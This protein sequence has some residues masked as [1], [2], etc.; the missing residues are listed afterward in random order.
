MKV[1]LAGVLAIAGAANAAE[2]CWSDHHVQ[3]M[4]MSDCD[5]QGDNGEP[6][7]ILGSD[8]RVIVLENIDLHGNPMPESVQWVNKTHMSP[9]KP[10][11]L[12]VRKAEG[13]Q[14]VRRGLNS[15]NMQGWWRDAV[16]TNTGTSTD[17]EYWV[18][19]MGLDYTYKWIEP[20]TGTRYTEQ[21][22]P[23]GY[24]AIED[25]RGPNS[26]RMAMNGGFL[27]QFESRKPWQI[28]VE[29]YAH[30]PT[31]YPDYMVGVE[32]QKDCVRDYSEQDG[33]FYCFLYDFPE[34]QGEMPSVGTY[35]FRGADASDPPSAHQSGCFDMRESVD[36]F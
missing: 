10:N 36:D 6:D 18:E 16:P 19:F 9:Q 13:Q 17:G 34:F 21:T 12:N 1:L 23:P 28:V 4:W 29:Y 20:M 5:Q 27:Y 7:P 33:M 15:H 2:V 24:L 32:Y 25:I 8:K 31:N 22:L 11:I 35:V 3:W 30:P 26:C 14:V